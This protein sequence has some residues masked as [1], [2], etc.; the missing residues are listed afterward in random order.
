[1]TVAFE[2]IQMKLYFAPLEG[3]TTHIY[4]NTHAQ[5]FGGCD[6]YFSPF[7]TPSDNEK[8]GRKGFRDILPENNSADLKVQVLTNNSA[9]FLKF[10]KKAAEYGYS[11]LNINLGCPSGT[12][13]GKNRGAGLLKN[14][15][16]LDRFLYEIFSNTNAKISV[17]TRAGYFSTLEIEELL[18]VYNKYPISLL[19]LHPRCR[20]DF[21]KGV[22]DEK[23][24]SYA[25]ENAK[26][27]LC[28]NGNIFTVEDYSR[29]C[30]Q[31]PHLDSVMIGRGAIA[32]PAIFRE[33][34][35]GAPLTTEELIA[36]TEALRENYSAIL[37]SDVFTL[38]KL[39]EIWLYIM[40]NFPDEKKIL[41]TIKKTN[42]LS[43]FMNAIYS[44]F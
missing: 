25:Y 21:Y 2:D 14:T 20:E 17:K 30:T 28:Y 23:A 8:I 44:L 36:F 18:C 29:V 31:Y 43:E 42:N 13:V 38:H 19:I 35:G 34:R 39:K 33:I 24:F 27:P 10:E 9:S 3:I 26:A 40:Q 15:D 4:R 12:V 1:M 37:D 6:A 22:P 11:E 16:A 32:N 41:K 5:L 7:I